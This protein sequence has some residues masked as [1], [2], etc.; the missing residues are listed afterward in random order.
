MPGEGAVI[1]SLGGALYAL[2]ATAVFM[3]CG[4][5][6]GFSDVADAAGAI[7]LGAGYRG[8]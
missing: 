8:S 6:L 3:S 4:A 5:A 7:C 2:P 1:A